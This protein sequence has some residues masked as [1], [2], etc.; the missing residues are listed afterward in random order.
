MENVRLYCD[1]TQQ[2]TAQH[3]P[4]GAVASS[5]ARLTTRDFGRERTAGPYSPDSHDLLGLLEG[6]TSTNVIKRKI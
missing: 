4:A 1:E 6:A 3:R 2:L 5:E